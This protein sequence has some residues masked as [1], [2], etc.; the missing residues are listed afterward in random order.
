M[1]SKNSDADAD[2]FASLLGPPGR[3]PVSTSTPGSGSSSGL[4][5]LAPTSP[6]APLATSAT[7][8]SAR[9]NPFAAARSA[10]AARTANAASLD[11]AKELFANPIT[12]TTTPASV[13]TTRVATPV[14]VNVNVNP[15]LKS[16]N[17]FDSFGLDQNLFSKKPPD[18]KSPDKVLGAL[19]LDRLSQADSLTSGMLVAPV[20]KVRAVNAA[21]PRSTPTTAN[22][23]INSVVSPVPAP[24]PPPP[25]ASSPPRPQKPSSRSVSPSTHS[26]RSKFMVPT[27]H[28]PISPPPHVTSDSTSNKQISSL[29]SPRQRSVSPSSR[30]ISAEHLP[31]PSSPKPPSPKIPI[32]LNQTQTELQYQV[33]HAIRPPS[34]V[35][36]KSIG[37]PAVVPPSFDDEFHHD[38]TF[39]SL[40]PRPTA[41]TYQT[42]AVNPFGASTTAQHDM[43]FSGFP[44][45]EEIDFSVTT[46]LPTT[47]ISHVQ[48]S[49]SSRASP[50]PTTTPTAIAAPS[51]RSPALSASDYYNDFEDVDR[52]PK[53]YG[54]FD[55]ASANEIKPTR[56]ES[57]ADELDDLVFGTTPSAT[58]P[59]AEQPLQFGEPQQQEDS[60]QQPDQPQQNH[61][62]SGFDGAQIDTVQYGDQYGYLQEQQ[63]QQQ[64]GYEGQEYQ[65]QYEQDEIQYSYDQGYSLDY[66]QHQYPQTQ[67]QYS[68]EN[69]GQQQKQ[70]HQYSQ[71]EYSHGN[72]GQE[73]EQQQQYAQD[74]PLSPQ[75]GYTELD[76]YDQ[77][78]QEYQ[79]PSKEHQQHQY[80][81][82]PNEAT[83]PSTDFASLVNNAPESVA[84]ISP[85]D[86]SAGPQQQEVGFFELDQYEQYEQS[87]ASVEARVQS[88]A[89]PF[90]TE[91]APSAV[92]AY[93]PFDAPLGDNNNQQYSEFDQYQQF[94]AQQSHQQDAGSET[95]N[96]FDTIGFN[97]ATHQPPVL[98]SQDPFGSSIPTHEESL[99]LF[100]G[101]VPGQSQ[102]PFDDFGGSGVEAESQFPPTPSTATA[103]VPPL[104]AVDSSP[105][106][107]AQVHELQPVV[108]VHAPVDTP[109][110][111]VESQN[112]EI[113]F[114]ASSV[115]ERDALEQNPFGQGSVAQNPFGGDA[116]AGYSQN[117]FDGVSTN[118]QNLFGVMQQ[119][120]A[121][122]AFSGGQD[123]QQQQF[124]QGFGQQQQDYDYSQHPG[125]IEQQQQQQEVNQS[126]NNYNAYYQQEGQQYQDQKGY[127]G[128]HQQQQEYDQY[129]T[130]QFE[131]YEQ[132]TAQDGYHGQAVAVQQQEYAQYSSQDYQNQHVSQQPTFSPPPPVATAAFAPPPP[133]AA[134]FAPPPPA[135]TF[136]PPPPVSAVAVPPATVVPPPPPKAASFVPPPTAASFQQPAPIA[137][138]QYQAPSVTESAHPPP[139]PKALPRLPPQ[140]AIPP[141][142]PAAAAFAP[143]PPTSHEVPQQQSVDFN[144][145]A[146]PEQYGAYDGTSQ[147]QPIDYNAQYENGAFSQNQYYE[148]YDQTQQ[149][150]YVQQDG[151][152]GY[153]YNNAGYYDQ[154]QQSLEQQ[155]YEGCDQ[156]VEQAQYGESASYG[157]EYGADSGYVANVVEQ[158]Y[159]ESYNTVVQ[160]E[161][162][163]PLAAAPTPVPPQPTHITCA[164]CAHQLEIG[165]LF[166]NKCGTRVPPQQTTPQ[167]VA[168]EMNPSHA[169]AA[170]T[171]APLPPVAA[172]ITPP[173][174][175][176]AVVPPPIA[177]IPLAGGA[178]AKP[179]TPRGAHRM[180]HTR[181]SNQGQVHEAYSQQQQPQQQYEQ[182]AQPTE[183]FRF[184]DPLGRHRGHAI[185]TFSFA[186]RL[187]ITSPQRMQRAQ[188]NQQTGASFM[189]EKSCPGKVKIVSVQQIIEPGALGDLILGVRTPVLGA[190]SRLKKKDVV[191]LVEDRVVK[192][193]TLYGEGKIVSEVVLLWKLV[194]ICLEGDGVLSGKPESIQA[195]RDLLLSYAPT[196]P[197]SAT[198]MDEI[199]RHLL[200]GDK[201]NACKVALDGGL[202]THALVIS[203]QIDKDTYKDVISSFAR[204]E[205][206]AGD[207][208]SIA[209]VHQL[210]RPG[211]R[212]LYSLFGYGGK[213]AISEFL[214]NPSDQQATGD[215]LALWQETLALI[216]SNKTPGDDLAVSAF[217]DLLFGYNMAV[218]A[219]ICYLL[220]P[221]H[222]PLSGADAPNVKAV[223]LGA[224]HVFN[225]SRYFKDFDALQLTEL[226]EFAQS[227]I[228]NAGLTGG[229]PH[230]QSHKLVYAHYLAEIGHIAESMAYCE[231]IEQVV[232]NYGK[233]SPYFHKTFIE[234][235]RDLTEHLAM[236]KPPTTAAGKME[237]KKK[238]SN[239]S[240]M[241]LANSL[242][243]TAAGED[244]NGQGP[245]AAAKDPATERPSF[246]LPPDMIRPL[247][248][249][250]GGGSQIGYSGGDLNGGSQGYANNNAG[251]EQGGYSNA[252]YATNDDYNNGGY[253]A[254]DGYFNMPGYQGYQGNTVQEYGNA[255]QGYYD[256][257]GN[258]QSY[259]NE[260][261]PNGYYDE[262]GNWWSND[263]QQQ[264]NLVENAEFN[265]GQVGYQDMGTDGYQNIQENGYGVYGNDQGSQN[266]Q[267]DG[268]QYVSDADGYGVYNENTGY[269]GGDGYG[270]NVV[271]GQDDARQSFEQSGY[272]NDYNQGYAG[273][274]S[275]NN[276]DNND[277]TRK[278]YGQNQV[279]EYGQPYQDDFEG[280]YEVA[281]AHALTPPPAVSTKLPPPPAASTKNPQPA[282]PPAST[283]T[284]NIPP[285]AAAS[286][287]AIPPP[288]AVTRSAPPAATAVPPK[289]AA[290]A[291]VA[292]SSRFSQP[293]SLSQH[294]SF[295]EQAPLTAES[296][297]RSWDQGEDDDL[298][299]GNKPLVTSPQTETPEPVTQEASSTTSE[300]P[301]ATAE[302]PKEERRKSGSWIPSISS[303][304]GRK[305]AEDK[306]KAE[307]TVYKA[308]LDSGLKLVFDQA[309][310]KWVHG[311]TKEAVATTATVAP[312]PMASSQSAPT[313]RLSTPT[314]NDPAP[315]PASG[316]SNNPSSNDV[317]GGQ[318]GVALGGNRKRGARNKYVD[319]MNPN[320]KPAAAPPAFKSFLPSTG[321]Q[322]VSEGALGEASMDESPVDAAS[323]SEEV[324]TPIAQP[325][326]V[327]QQARHSV[328]VAPTSRQSA[329]IPTQNNFG[330]RPPPPQQQ[331]Q[332]Q[333]PKQPQ[334]GGSAPAPHRPQQQFVAPTSGYP[335]QPAPPANNVNTGYQ[336]ITPATGP[337]SAGASFGGG[338]P[339]GVASPAAKPQ[340]GRRPIRPPGHSAAPSDI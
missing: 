284:T 73:Q 201:A 13:A 213:G 173:L 145:N 232:K 282:P 299:F 214:L 28:R 53:K 34:P 11:K 303:L 71:E 235:L 228:N 147:Q 139:P 33:S 17:F 131:S 48:P 192:V 52:A 277:L 137:S 101:S 54:V 183:Q 20:K 49:P 142:T 161:N 209:G 157:Q 79:N 36:K 80:D 60:Q 179:P 246:F 59:T 29:I 292:A 269:N 270:Q 176:S 105:Q 335:S 291:P 302:T 158:P 193:E 281:P 287:K 328:P 234:S 177:S 98:N 261:E 314:P 263:Q 110:P 231:S 159:D 223:L 47:T 41:V 196:A 67:Q 150:E 92:S 130:S 241:G 115:P 217:G 90:S 221:V 322:I 56:R 257:H 132:Q 296:A 75:L 27:A 85:I 237:L 312:P 87:A 245:P 293:T 109:T 215:A 311:G 185:A 259:G 63:E 84:I 242:L 271:Y 15:E 91:T 327:Q 225:P 265:D 211:L 153:D 86:A 332:I 169:V 124:A 200:R 309:Q 76:H 89:V 31:K 3:R 206:S 9:P 210:D 37:S 88:D 266:A 326:P 93:N 251:N 94:E 202:W 128:E 141:P 208:G 100:G 191:K 229:I 297:K 123:Q 260:G 197:P 233:P 188:V 152:Y 30:R 6:Q 180:A 199:Q 118:E 78:S 117:P 230:L 162:A 184:I 121:F 273:S 300:K 276:F 313:S 120:V 254:N 168:A 338:V 82:F 336:R 14:N 2:F 106:P 250:G 178:G 252:G 203:A 182:Q 267:I 22:E 113:P 35:L 108:E 148:N 103:F 175:A 224:N 274:E 16:D 72:Y 324:T 321:V 19:G 171:S 219:H 298:G 220:S 155:Q 134:V 174:Q 7:S 308:N 329:P 46:H 290:S 307:K 140:A 249:A 315:R 55:S 83:S 146:A 32:A 74:H 58:V 255:P 1:S 283:A 136:A 156:N 164:S 288:A 138:F 195:V 318:Y 99:N 18:V 243:S 42:D 43:D 64:Y 333:P 218:P 227:L 319:V 187:V 194:K 102:Y 253:T 61:G 285:P 216:L 163:T 38:D 262:H 294:A 325:A 289:A 96:P 268:G 23:P 286:F 226:F 112:N 301:V 181:S 50:F 272:G 97:V 236:V 275:H 95:V 317:T 295:N 25:R 240:L 258:P 4:S 316:L 280:E 279:D 127:Q 244:I 160:Q 107:V 24:I 66:Q 40:P 44:G 114:G 135:N 264:Q 304:F 5:P 248:T 111:V 323:L 21:L 125:Y 167:P 70:Q 149:Q 204:Q 331:Q 207:S 129:A 39:S 154:Q 45:D 337:G 190:R 238:L 222:S 133:V 340:Q 144:T 69:Y 247:S 198:K 65:Q 68:H 119:E 320:G 122:D 8:A 310:K 166:C 12:R 81:S 116:F 151:G 306:D 186:G 212:V 143:P 172:G 104:A 278:T 170:Q 305:P 26:E 51:K 339:R 62:F 330:Q 239:F 77:L 165:S 126:G 205:F 334:F 57:V 256:E 189:V 10:R